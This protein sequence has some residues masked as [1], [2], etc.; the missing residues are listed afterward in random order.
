MQ[1]FTVVFEGFIEMERVNHVGFHTSGINNMLQ[2]NDDFSTVQ[3]K[4]SQMGLFSWF[5]HYTLMG[6][7]GSL[8]PTVALF[9]LE[10][11][12]HLFLGQRS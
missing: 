11:S 9:F 4:N 3:E 7:Y 10:S 6:N 8:L 1:G 5:E 2:F 12:L